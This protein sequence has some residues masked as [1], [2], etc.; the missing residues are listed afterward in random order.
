[1][2]NF[3]TRSIAFVFAMMLLFSAGA[4]VANEAKAEIQ[5]FNSLEAKQ[6]D[7]INGKISNFEYLIYINMKSGRSFNS[8]SHYPF[9]PWIL[10]DY[11]S[12]TI[13]M[14]KKCLETSKNQLV[15]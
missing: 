12:E 4:V 3:L 9:F 5:R 11:D 8:T 1:M 7:W 2:N 15:H 14:M 6:S 10:N 13:S